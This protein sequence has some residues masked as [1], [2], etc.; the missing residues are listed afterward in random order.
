MTAAPHSPAPSP[1]PP[2]Q[3]PPPEPVYSPGR[4]LT[5][6][7]RRDR[8]WRMLTV[9]GGVLLAVVVVLSLVA[10]T[11]VPWL[12]TKDLPMV[13]A[14]QELGTPS[15]LTL[16]TDV[17]DVTVVRDEAATQV[18][19]SL[20]E[21]GSLTPAAAGEQVRAR[22]TSEGTAQDPVLIVRQ[23]AGGGPIPWVD[24]TRD[25]LVVLPPDLAP[26]LDL[27]TDVGDVRA[28]GAVG[29]L[30]VTSSVGSVEVE[31]LTA[32]G[33]VQVSANSGDVDLG[34]A[35]PAAQGVEVENSLGDVDVRL[36]PDAEGDVSVTADLGQVSVQVP[37][38]ARRTVDAQ[39]DAGE[40]QVDPSITGAAGESVGA[41]TIRADLGDVAVQR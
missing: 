39:A 40:V 32:S 24:E 30:R 11:L 9:L 13:P 34:L 31:D 17:A 4:R 35:A 33:P 28:D 23:P 36:A 27:T 8:P 14:T 1:A 22:I 29:A 38:T 5:P 19:V 20:V 16:T 21:S 18:E 2:L 37:G 3:A 10:S 25:L 15:S 41:I 7:P 26:D 12:L 6:D